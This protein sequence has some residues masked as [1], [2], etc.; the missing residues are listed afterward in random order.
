MKGWTDHV[1]SISREKKQDEPCGR[2]FI[3]FAIAR[4]GVLLTYFP[5]LPFNISIVIIRHRKKSLTPEIE[6]ESSGRWL[7]GGALTLPTVE[8]PLFCLFISPWH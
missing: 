1:G 5:N 3:R 7:G 4:A 2:L 6:A 8:G